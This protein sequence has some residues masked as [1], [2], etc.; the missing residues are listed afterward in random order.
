MEIPPTFGILTRVDS[1][2]LW[3]LSF[4]WGKASQIPH[5]KYDQFIFTYQVRYK[6]FCHTWTEWYT[7]T[8]YV[9]GSVIDTGPVRMSC[10]LSTNSLGFSFL[11]NVLSFILCCLFCVEY[12]L[13]RYILSKRT[14]DTPWF[15]MFCIVFNLRQIWFSGQPWGDPVRLKGL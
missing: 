11:R 6:H 13:V 1:A 15:R 7:W 5:T 4:V 8:G 12:Y 3:Q 10:L 14:R 2:T 9:C